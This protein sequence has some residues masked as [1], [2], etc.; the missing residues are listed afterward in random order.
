MYYCY[1]LTL[2]S[3]EVIIISRTSSME[4]GRVRDHNKAQHDWKARQTIV[5][6]CVSHKAYHNTHLYNW[7]PVGCYGMP[8]NWIIAH[9]SWSNNYPGQINQW[10][11]GH[12]AIKNITQTN[13]PLH[14]NTF[15]SDFPC[16]CRIV[17]PLL[18]YN[19]CFT[20]GSQYSSSIFHH[21]KKTTTTKKK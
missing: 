16:S 1:T 6:W 19:I 10:Q 12:V 17:L 15:S 5:S 8:L 11:Y 18:A 21:L 2:K 9:V 14:K 3:L 20:A 13:H 4:L 7:R